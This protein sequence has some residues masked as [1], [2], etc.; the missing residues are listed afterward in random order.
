VQWQSPVIT[1][2]H[3][4]V[5]LHWNKGQKCRTQTTVG[6]RI[7]QLSDAILLSFINMSSLRWF[8]Q[9]EHRDNAL[10][11]QALYD[12]R[13]RL[14][15]DSVCSVEEDMAYFAW[16]EKMHRFRTNGEEKSN[17]NWLMQDHLETG[18]ENSIFVWVNE[19]VMSSN[20][21]ALSNK[22]ANNLRVSRAIRRSRM[23]GWSWAL[24]P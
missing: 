8:R 5:S 10:L 3:W 7:T 21:I 13:G 14:R 11:V 18:S 2:S 19:Y 6:T 20:T 15:E 16:S 1:R 24:N 4:H 12:D 9:A 22:H 23:C 17:D